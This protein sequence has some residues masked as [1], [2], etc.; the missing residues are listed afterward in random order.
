MA[1]RFLKPATIEWLKS[2]GSLNESEAA[3]L[4]AD[5]EA[6]RKENERLQ[7]ALDRIGFYCAGTDLEH[8]SNFVLKVKSGE[9][10]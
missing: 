7:K 4:I 10:V 2:K 8:V 1:H 6:Y 3:E 5:L 9:Q